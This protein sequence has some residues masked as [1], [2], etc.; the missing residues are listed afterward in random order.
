MPLFGI[1]DVPVHNTDQ[2]KLEEEEND[3]SRNIVNVHD[4][5]FLWGVFEH[6]DRALMRSLGTLSD[7]D[8][9]RLYWSCHYHKH[10][11]VCQY[12]L[13]NCAPV[14]I[15]RD[16]IEKLSEMTKASDSKTPDLSQ[17]PVP[18]L[19]PTSPQFVV[20]ELCDGSFIPSKGKPLKFTVV[21]REGHKKT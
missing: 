9:S 4:P 3:D 8:C 11:T 18:F 2:I 19:L 17:I 15:A 20:I 14:R 16:A 13:D 21:N 6:S 10:E 12:L 5:F 7:E 1:T